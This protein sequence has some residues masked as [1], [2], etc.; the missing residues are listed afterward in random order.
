[1]KDI[2]ILIFNAIIFNFIIAHPNN[3]NTVL[4]VNHF[5]VLMQ[6]FFIILNFFYKNISIKKDV[7]HAILVIL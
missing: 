4:I 1:M 6:A 2:A 7:R 3:A 5:L